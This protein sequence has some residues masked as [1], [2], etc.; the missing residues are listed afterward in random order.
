MLEETNDNLQGRWKISKRNYRINT[1]ENVLI[2]E[3]MAEEV[4]NE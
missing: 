1:T 3:V 2:E 4:I